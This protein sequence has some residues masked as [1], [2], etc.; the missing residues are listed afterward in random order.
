MVFMRIMAFVVTRV[1]QCY[2]PA[3][4]S[5][6]ACLIP[7]RFAVMDPAREYTAQLI[8]VHDPPLKLCLN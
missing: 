5:K 6:R 8:A 4:H 7:L 1:I 3:C 2:L